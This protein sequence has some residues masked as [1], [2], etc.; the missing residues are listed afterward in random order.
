MAS[1][2]ERAIRE[3]VRAWFAA[4][5]SGDTKTVLSLMTDDALF[6]VPGKEPF[7]KEAFEK[8]SEGMK[9]VKFEG[10]SDIKE[11]KI[12]SDWAYLRS[13]IDMTVTPKRGKPIH[14]SGYTL[15]ILKKEQGIWKLTRDANLLTIRE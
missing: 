13:Y 10:S 9:D 11:L 14:R 1:K 7:G 6:I 12:L 2:D 4:S 3:L 8:A 15:T 5:K